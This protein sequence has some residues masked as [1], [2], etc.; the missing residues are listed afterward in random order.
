[1]GAPENQLYE[2]PTLSPTGAV[3]MLLLLLGV[4]FTFLARSRR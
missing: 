1:V 4:A 3:V 2:I